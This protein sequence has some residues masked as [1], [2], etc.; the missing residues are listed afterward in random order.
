MTNPINATPYLRTTRD[1]PEDTGEMSA[2]INKAY[3]EIA[4]ATNNRT[5]GIY[6]VNK[7]SINGNS[8]YIQ[9]KRQQGLRQM[10]TFTTTADIP[11]GFKL[12]NI[13]GI[14]QMYGNYISSAGGTFTYGLIPGTSV[15]IGGQISFYIVV[16]PGDSDVIRFAVD[17]AAPA[18][19]SGII[20]VEWIANV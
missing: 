9:S 12:I 16:V 20:V 5:I 2:E 11:L 17:G 19:T 3:L 10:Y 14:V 13:G 1:F 18:L 6:S 7:P 15:A 8:F 4:A